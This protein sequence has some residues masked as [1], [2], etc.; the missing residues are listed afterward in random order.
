MKICFKIISAI[1]ATIIFS[2]FSFGQGIIVKSG[3][4]IIKYGGNMILSG[5]WV[6]DGT[7]TDS[8]GTL[9]FSGTTQS[10]GGASLSTFNNIYVSSTS[11]T[12]I[13]TAGQKIAGILLVD[14]TLNADG[15]LTLI[16]TVS[17][18]ALINGAGTG[19]VNGN[20]T[21]ERYLPSEFGSK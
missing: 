9:T 1:I 14:G 10:I 5:S 11:T 12:S 18:T 2:C 19:Q 3:S 6:T 17:G 13:L 7:F 21:M 15:N 16:S 8:G 20:V 4:N